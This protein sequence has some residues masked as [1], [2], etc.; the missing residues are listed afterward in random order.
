MKS[1]PSIP[2]NNPHKGGNLYATVAY[3][4]TYFLVYF[5]PAQRARLAH[6]SRRQ[7]RIP[8]QWGPHTLTQ[9][10]PWS[11]LTLISEEHSLYKTPRHT[12]RHLSEFQKGHHL[13]KPLPSLGRVLQPSRYPT[14]CP[15]KFRYGPLHL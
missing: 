4:V 5:P 10:P 1:L 11:N 6:N 9:P 12:H 7:C 13:A 3:V 15:L 14:P 2:G 8:R